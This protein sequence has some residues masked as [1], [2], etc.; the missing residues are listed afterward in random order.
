VAIP[1]YELAGVYK[2]LHFGQLVVH[3]DCVQLKDGLFTDRFARGDEVFQP[4]EGTV[5]VDHLKVLS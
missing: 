3:H 4:D 5:A 1:R 2:Y